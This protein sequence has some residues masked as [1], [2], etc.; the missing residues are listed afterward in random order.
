MPLFAA[1]PKVKRMT[2]N[3]KLSCADNLCGNL[4]RTA[5]WRRGMK[6]KFPDDCRNDKAAET[7]DKLAGDALSL[8]DEQWLELKKFFNWSSSTWSD[9]VSLAS[10]HVEFQR[11]VRTFLAFVDDLVHILSQPATN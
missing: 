10:R 3:N 2:I 4:S 8:S 11:N 6:A 5:T 9:A 7:L 1:T